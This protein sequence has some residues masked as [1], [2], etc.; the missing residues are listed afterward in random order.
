MSSG[1]KQ[2]N[3]RAR[4]KVAGVCT[5]CTGPRDDQTVMDCS[6]CRVKSNARVREIVSS[7]IRSGRCRCG[8]PR[9]SERLKTCSQC[10]QRSKDVLRDLKLKVIAGYGGKCKCCGTT[11]FEFLSLDHVNNDGASDRRQLGKKGNSGSLYRLVIAER[12]PKRFQLLCYNCNLSLAFFGYCPHNPGFQR[13]VIR[14]RAEN[15]T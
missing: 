1:I 8:Q 14:R 6:G 7:N 3:R 9:I 12:F 15:K 13:L 10:A 4:L 2:K 5:R 11:E